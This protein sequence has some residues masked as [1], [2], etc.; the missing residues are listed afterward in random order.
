M[1]LRR[2][3]SIQDEDG[4]SEAQPTIVQKGQAGCEY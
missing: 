3:V 1:I 4:T 2:K